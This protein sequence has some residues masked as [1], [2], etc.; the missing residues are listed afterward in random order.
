MMHCPRFR[1]FAALAAAALL[2]ALFQ[3]VQAD[4]IVTTQG[5]SLQGVIVDENVY[6]IYLDTGGVVVP[7]PHERVKI[8]ERLDVEDN[9]R[10]LLER[11]QEA[12]QNGDLS[13]ARTLLEQ[14]R[15][16]TVT[17]EHLLAQRL[18]LD[19]ELTEL[20]RHGGTL[21][22]RRENA[23]DLLRRAQEAYDRIDDDLGNDLL[24]QSLLIDPGLPEAHELIGRRLTARGKPDLLLAGEY[25]GQILWPDNLRPDSPIVPLLPQVYRYLIELFL[26]TKDDVRAPHYAQL[27]SKLNEAFLLH[28]E[29]KN[30]PGIDAA[31]RELLERPFDQVLAE[32]V[33]IN[34][35]A[36]EYGLAVG[37]LQGWADPSVSP[38]M[39]LLIA[40]ANT[41][42]GHYDAAIAALEVATARFPR[43]VS[44][45]P[46][47][48]ALK[49]LAEG[50]RQEQ[51]GN[52]A[53]A[54]EFYE[55]VFA[56]RLQLVEE[57]GQAV[58]S[59][60]A[61]IKAPQM[62]TATG[63]RGDWRLADVAALVMNFGSD[64]GQQRRGA[65]TLSQQLPL[66]PWHLKPTLQVNGADLPTTA[67][68]PLAIA[69]ALSRPLAVR[70]NEESPF[71]LTFR[72]NLVCSPEDY[73]RLGTSVDREGRFEINPPVQINNITFDLVAFH[74]TL[75][76]LLEEDWSPPD[77]AEPVKQWRAQQPNFPAADHPVYLYLDSA[78]KLAQ[79]L[80][81]EMPYYLIPEVTILPSRLNLPRMRELLTTPRATPVGAAP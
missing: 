23:R 47:L 79:F 77:V 62:D 15:R 19:T 6:N 36:G 30:A 43:D 51:Q 54:T 3:P 41:G 66:A 39:A 4:K 1:R 13:T 68:I 14:V 63:S 61:T 60:L 49:L 7:I 5:Q 35:N 11:A 2:P 58:G 81:N 40:R 75:G 33:Q 73:Q 9:A 65:R 17:D 38:E 27:V 70:F 48:N 25:F 34:L 71:E 16:L 67:A 37:K 20:E 72:I 21:A 55:K 46:Q 24:I 44:L 64:L 8:V 53:E 76:I 42:A 18:R 59:R 50:A 26:T 28:P 80:S 32:Q 56:N 74:P 52:L 45:T 12:I 31:T 69:Q 29:W 22:Q 10:Q 57:I 78:T